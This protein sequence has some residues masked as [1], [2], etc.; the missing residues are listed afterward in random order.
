MTLIL[1]FTLDFHKPVLPRSWLASSLTWAVVTL[2]HHSPVY[3]VLHCTAPVAQLG[4]RALVFFRETIRSLDEEVPTKSNGFMT[5]SISPSTPVFR[6]PA[7]GRRPDRCPL[8]YL[9]SYIHRSN[10]LPFNFPHVS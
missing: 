2:A 4:T 6:V 10:A 1:I 7:L 9:S 3:S 8:L 5:L